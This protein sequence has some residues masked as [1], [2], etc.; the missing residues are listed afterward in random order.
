VKV[1]CVIEDG[2]ETE[3]SP[4]HFTL[5]N[6]S[7]QC[8]AGRERSCRLL[9]DRRE[10]IFEPNEASPKQIQVWGLFA[11]SDGKP[12]NGYLQPQYGYMYFK[13][14]GGRE[15]EILTLAEWTDLKKV[16]GTGSVI[17]FA[18]RPSWNGRLRKATDK[19]ESPDAYPL[20]NGIT[21]VSQGRGL[22][23]IDNPAVIAQLKA[24][25][26]PAR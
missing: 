14:D 11:L 15:R 22:G 9:R 3:L 24:A 2:Y 1:T 26:K 18:E 6:R 25:I 12:G 8:C 4:C 23:S 16:A 5:W 19:P 20:Y 17:T 13:L 21:R 7:V 10:V